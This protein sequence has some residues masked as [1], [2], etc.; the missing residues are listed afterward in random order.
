MKD[1]E[2]Q[3]IHVN[4]EKQKKILEY[5][6]FYTEGLVNLKMAIK[7][8]KTGKEKMKTKELSI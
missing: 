6:R 2:F 3:Q 1:G 7:S 8:I 4:F 5:S